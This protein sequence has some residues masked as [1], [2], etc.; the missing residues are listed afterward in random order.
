MLT[1][2][3]LWLGA[4]MVAIGILLLMMLQARQERRDTKTPRF[5]ERASILISV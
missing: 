2:R 3:N 5:D 4:T 1:E